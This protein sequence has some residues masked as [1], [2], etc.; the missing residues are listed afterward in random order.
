[1]PMPTR[2]WRLIVTATFSCTAPLVSGFIGQIYRSVKPYDI[3]QFELLVAAS[4]PYPEP[5]ICC[6]DGRHFPEIHPLHQRRSYSVYSSISQDG[7]TWNLPSGRGRK[8]SSATT[9]TASTFI[10]D[11]GHYV[12]TYYLRGQLWM[13]MNWHPE[14][15]VK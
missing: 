14:G 7:L 9:A 3:S 6:E 11:G 13:A 2:A 8:K 12:T 5:W 10:A 15:R 4:I 1:M